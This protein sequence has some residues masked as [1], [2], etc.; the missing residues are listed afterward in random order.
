MLVLDIIAIVFS[1]V[2]I[3]FGVLALILVTHY[4]REAF[5]WEHVSGK[6][7][8]ELRAHQNRSSDSDNGKDGDHMC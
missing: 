6:L 2:A 3:V 1:I 4:R 5:Y 7:W 8:D